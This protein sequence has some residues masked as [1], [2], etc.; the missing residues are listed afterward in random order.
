MLY[1]L[2]KAY[3][4][5]N[6]SSFLTP[7]ASKKLERNHVFA[8][9]KAGAGAVDSRCDVSCAGVAGAAIVFSAL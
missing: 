1:P 7:A 9:T 5:L 3:D 8:Y 2:G 6:P 4:R